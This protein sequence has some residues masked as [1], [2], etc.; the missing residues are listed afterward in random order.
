MITS[1]FYAAGAAKCL[2]RHLDRR[3]PAPVPLRELVK[4]LVT[5][6]VERDRRDADLAVAQRRD[7]GPGLGI[8]GDRGATDP[9][10]RVAVWIEALDELVAVVALPELRHFDA[11]DA[12]ARERR[13]V[14]VEERVVDEALLKY[15][16]LNA[17]DQPPPP[18]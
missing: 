6:G 18:P 4:E 1:S 15:A 9:V 2:D 17:P 12:L 5:R 7:I 8:F 11:G 13:A 3:A 14:H 16:L 10:V